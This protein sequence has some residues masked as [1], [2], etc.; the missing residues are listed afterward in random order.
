M[1]I[2]LVFHD[3]QDRLGNSIYNAIEGINLSGGDLHHGSTFDGTIECDEDTVNDIKDALEAGARPVF[4]LVEA[5]PDSYEAYFET[6][7]EIV[8]KEAK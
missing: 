4:R 2:K 5:K 7:T 1:K 8:D 3:W 6:H